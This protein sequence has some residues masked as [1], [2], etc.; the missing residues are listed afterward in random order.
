RDRRVREAAALA[1]AGRPTAVEALRG[2]LEDPSVRVR[3]A[4]A[5]ALASDTDSV[6]VLG[7]TLADGSVRASEAALYALSTARDQEFP[8][9]TWI[10]GEVERARYL[11]THR[12]ALGNSTARPSCD[13]LRRLLLMRQRRLERWALEAMRVPEIEAAMPVVRHAVWSRDAETRAQALEALDSIPDRA[14]IRGLISLL[15]DEPRPDSLDARTSIRDLTHDFDYWI[16]AL[17]TRCSVDDLVDDLDSLLAMA[18]SVRDPSGLMGDAVSRW[19]SPPMDTTNHLGLIDR[20][21]A[22]QRVHMFSDIDP[23]DLERIAQVTIER[24]YQPDEIIYRAGEPGGEMLLI[25]AGDVAVRLPD[26]GLIRTYGVGQPVGELALLRRQPRSADVVAGASGVG[27]L[28][29]VADE[30]QAILEE[31]P[32]VAMAML[33]TLADRIADSGPAIAPDPPA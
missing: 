14:R 15:E 30:F 31:R 8:F 29:L 18:G 1:M 2:L 7:Q 26:G 19:K 25:V 3:S 13:Y 33:A 32:E 23:E 27:A 22:L 12:L 5:K 10:S 9:G 28:V 6:G 4:A 16:R 21:L 17:A 20:V 11:Q 24:R